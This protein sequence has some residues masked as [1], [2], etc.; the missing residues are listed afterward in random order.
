VRKMEL[1]IF[2]RAS[3][4]SRAWGAV[5][6][7]HSILQNH[8]DGVLFLI[9]HVLGYG[10]LLLVLLNYQG[11][12]LFKR[13]ARDIVTKL[14]HKNDILVHNIFSAQVRHVRE[15]YLTFNT[16]CLRQI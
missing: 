4:E 3:L 16:G 13:N 14:Q 8:R 2:S 9:A 10:R 7:K 11:C 15:V 1:K 6:R 12:L 5:Q